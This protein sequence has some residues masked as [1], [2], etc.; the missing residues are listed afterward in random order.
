M[1]IASLVVSM[2][3]DITAFRRGLQ[4]A[5]SETQR[6]TN[7]I[8][9]SFATLGVA[10]GVREVIQ[11]ADAWSLAEG[12][13]RLFTR[14][15]DETA[16]VQEQLFQ[17]AQDNRQEFSETV[18]LFSRLSLG[19]RE[20]GRSQSELLQITR[21]VG[22]A[23]RI[24]NAATSESV[25][26]MRQLA[27]ALGSGKFQ[28][29]E[30]RSIVENAPVLAQAIADALGVT[31]S[32]LRELGAEGKVIPAQ[33]AQAILDASEKINAAAQGLPTTIGQSFTRLGNSIQKFIG[34][35]AK[36]TG[37]A[38]GL[39]SVINA[40]GNAFDKNRPLIESI[41]FALGISGLTAA[42]VLLTKAFIALPIA[43][44]VVSWF[45][46]GGAMGPILPL[47]VALRVGFTALWTAILGPVGLAIAGITALTAL[48]F[49]WRKRAAEARA[50]TEKLKSEIAG[51][52]EEQIRLEVTDAFNDLQRLRVTRLALETEWKRRT[53][54][55]LSAFGVGRE[56]ANVRVESDETLKRLNLLIESLNKLEES[57]P[58][59]PKV[60]F[61]FEAFTKQGGR[62]LDLFDDLRERAEAINADK[63]SPFD[64]KGL[65]DIRLQTVGVVSQLVKLFETTEQKLAKIK[66]KTSD[67]AVALR[68]LAA[69][70]RNNVEALSAIRIEQA[71]VR[72][73][74]V[75][76]I[77]PPPITET[78]TAL[79]RALLPVAALV[80]SQFGDAL[81]NAIATH[82]RLMAKPKLAVIAE[83]TP[84]T[85][86]D[87]RNLQAQIDRLIQK[88]GL[89]D[90]AALTGDKAFETEA[91]ANF[92]T[93]LKQTI[94]TVRNLAEAIR[95][96]NLPL[97]VQLA[98]LI[99]LGGI[100][101]KIPKP[102]QDSSNSLQ[103]VVTAGRGLS[104][105]AAEFSN[106]NKNVLKVVS[107]ILDAVAAVDQ[108]N[109]AK[110]E[111]D[112]LGQI[113]GALGVVGGVVSLGAALGDALF[114]A[115]RE[116]AKE[117]REILR[118]NNEELAQLT[119]AL[120][121]FQGTLGDQAKL[122]QDL[123]NLLGPA[124]RLAA[125]RPDFSGVGPPDISPVL[126]A[127]EEFRQAVAATGF[128]IQEL[129]EIGKEWGIT[130][131]DSHGRV[132]PE[133]V[134]QFVERM[135]LARQ[136]LFQ[137]Q[138]TVEDVTLAT[139]LRNAA[140]GIEDTP[141][142]IVTD[143]LT[144]LGTLAP[145]IVK[146]FFAGIDLS[147]GISE[148]E[149][150][151]IRR[152]S[153]KL[154]EQFLAGALNP[155]DLLGFKTPEEFAAFILNWLDALNR[156]T[157]ATNEA[158]RAM[159]NVP[160]GFKLERLRFE[161]QNPF[162]NPNIIQQITPLHPPLTPTS[163]FPPGIVP[164]GG[165]TVNFN[166][167]IDIDGTGKSPKEIARETALE[168][169]RLARARGP[170]FRRADGMELV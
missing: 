2:A 88:H 159:I 50:E 12:R 117:Q 36:A 147:D 11:Y 14:S 158:T 118:R 37:A 58:A 52:G 136:A 48:F 83:F 77:Q 43:Q 6:F 162:V 19:A 155:D 153:Q 10:L 154:V 57:K 131:L 79:N 107:S 68:Q 32:E 139:R 108:F 9:S 23:L 106:I 156:M 20:L 24:S 34:Q 80:G 97:A 40:V 44:T 92:D 73:P 41:T 119:L 135:K 94:S 70:I 59:P 145:Q 16:R 133:A 27:Q 115:A 91:L 78:E 120:K 165:G 160:T 166:V 56:L 102:L 61:D 113:S 163:P 65:A 150:A 15:A 104:Q 69:D 146:D 35:T 116:A 96:A 5:V 49:L 124:E 28:G 66:D 67:E 7:F 46:L 81:G 86:N 71:K 90:L 101:G 47:T 152:Q 144:Q 8:R 111:K 125:A 126:R 18:T 26:T 42:L 30:L 167:D 1:T 75:P 95:T 25:S 151:E 4:Q 127:V 85:E 137:F 169:S 82:L 143:A 54:L 138:N 112:I 122:L 33:V 55:G 63:I 132:I 129:N 60:T 128:T 141:Q 157:E 21:T 103:K 53:E 22:Q 87:F 114:G 72:I 3:T 39:V 121:G 123:Q 51:M 84:P 76:E 164:S 130:L 89:V 161:S 168:F 99:R 105:I 109:K 170:S 93:A 98:L 74:I 134:G 45:L 149:I 62:L 38:E 100:A 140:A 64:A 17:V 148:S 13:I 31:I 29:D 110:K 142:Q